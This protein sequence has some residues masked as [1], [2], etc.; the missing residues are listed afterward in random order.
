M[1]VEPTRPAW[2]AAVPVEVPVEIP[3]EIPAE[4]PVEAPGESPLEMPGESPLELPG[5]LPLEVPGT[6]AG[7]SRY[8]FFLIFINW[9]QRVGTPY[10]HT[11]IQLD[12]CVMLT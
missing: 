11:N 12:Q 7:Q 8:V 10:Q 6:P 2:E 4:S 9:L 5:E 1:T 3:V